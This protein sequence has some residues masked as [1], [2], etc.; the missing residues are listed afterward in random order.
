MPELESR[1]GPRRKAA[2]T[3]PISIDEAIALYPGK[4]LLMKVTE[5][6]ES[7]IP[8][9]GVIVAHGTHRKVSKKLDEL[10]PIGGKLDGTYYQFCANPGGHPRGR[11]GED[12]RKALE[13][14]EG[15]PRAWRW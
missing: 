5:F 15:D 8:S 4:W 2:T 10:W 1:L 9:H 14:A 7:H 6:D 11:T 12:L 13:R 3:K